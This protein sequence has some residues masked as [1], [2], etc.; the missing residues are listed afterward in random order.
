VAENDKVP[1]D[2]LQLT[3]LFGPVAAFVLPLLT[4]GLLGGFDDFQLV[5]KPITFLQSL[6]ILGA[7]CFPFGAFL[8]AR[9]KWNQSRARLSRTWPTVPGQVQS[10][11][12]ERR[13]TGLPAVLWRLALSYSY[14]VSENSYRGDAVQF[15]AKYVSSK[16]LIQA[17][18]KKYPPGA[19]ITVHYDPDDPGTSVIE[20]SD[21]MAR[22]NSWQIWLYFLT[23]IV[24]SIVVAIKNSGP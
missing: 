20:T 2:F 12:M 19:A 23:P 3:M 1:A 18:A 7:M 4:V 15:G 17:Q 6:G 10:S 8:F 21:E 9:R 5:N 13:I 24:I 22:Q 11:E 16:E 14:R